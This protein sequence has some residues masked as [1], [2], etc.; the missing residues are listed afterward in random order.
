ELSAKITDSFTTVKGW[1]PKTAWSMETLSPV[2]V[3]PTT[4]CPPA[5]KAKTA[6]TSRVSSC[7]IQSWA[8]AGRRR[9]AGRELDLN[10]RFHQEAIMEIS[11]RKV[12]RENRNRNF[13]HSAFRAHT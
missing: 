9:A 1:P 6:G 8:R 11:S 10:K 7:S 2:P 12:K 5:G 4:S 13:Y 3:A